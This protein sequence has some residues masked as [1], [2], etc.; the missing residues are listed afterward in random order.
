MDWCVFTSQL[1]PRISDSLGNT[2]QA[3]G[4]AW[5]WQGNEVRVK[6]KHNPL[7]L[8]GIPVSQGKG[9]RW[10]SPAQLW[11]GSQPQPLLE[12][13]QLLCTSASTGNLI[14]VP[15]LDREPAHWKTH[16]KPHQDTSEQ[17]QKAKKEK[18]PGVHTHIVQPCHCLPAP[19]N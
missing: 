6:A 4:E 17:A 18:N 10:L 11:A 3:L 7:G 16:P 15:K 14:Y 12:H 1:F 2:H 9:R 8:L 5:L 13:P 19:F